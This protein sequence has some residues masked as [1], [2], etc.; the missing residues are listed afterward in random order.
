MAT[1]NKK[2]LTL[3]IIQHMHMYILICMCCIIRGFFFQRNSH[4]SAW[5]F[6]RQTEIGAD[7]TDPVTVSLHS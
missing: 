7:G 2:G 4:A 6:D 3:R 1:T 5:S